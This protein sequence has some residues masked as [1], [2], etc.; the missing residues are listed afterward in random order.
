MFT[1]F[2]ILVVL[3][4]VSGDV[5]AKA[6]VDSGN[7]AWLTLGGALYLGSFLAW[8]ATLKHADLSRSI[9]IFS[10]A[11]VIGVAVAGIAL[12]GERLE[13]RTVIGLGLAAA[14]IFVMES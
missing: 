14:A 6:F 10:A 4:E 12:F 9:A 5:A 7:L 13:P 11:E 2:I 1:L 3:A 8:T